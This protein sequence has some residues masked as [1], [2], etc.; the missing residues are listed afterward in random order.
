MG[1]IYGVQSGS[2]LDLIFGSSQG[3][4]MCRDL[5]ST[6]KNGDDDDDDTDHHHQEI[7]RLAHMYTDMYLCICMCIY[8]Y[9][10]I[11]IYLH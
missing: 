10:F 3:S 5:L 6:D 2:L 7:R 8:I 4:G 11:F 9:I 1:S